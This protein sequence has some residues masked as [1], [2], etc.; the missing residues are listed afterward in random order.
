MGCNSTRG[1]GDLEDDKKYADNE[2]RPDD[3]TNGNT[4][5]KNYK[6]N[7]NDNN[8]NKNGKNANNKNANNINKNNGNKNDNKNTNKDDKNYGTKGD[9]K[10]TKNDDKN[11]GNKDVKKDGNTKGESKE[12][13]NINTDDNTN[14]DNDGNREARKVNL[15]LQKEDYEGVLLMQG[16]DDCFPED[17]TEEDVYKLVQDA[18][19]DKIVDDEEN[20]E[21]GTINTKQA[22]AIANILYNKINKK[23]TDNKINLKKYPELKG[24]NC[25]VGVEKFT[26]DVVK[27]MMF[28]DKKVDDKQIDKAYSKI[29]KDNDEYKALTIEILQ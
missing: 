11:S 7:K 23:D 8:D 21:P 10:N 26:K 2:S 1:F 19:N 25:K 5:N 27:K 13:E 28:Q 9:N 14:Q 3:D 16:F 17:L 24:V 29:N 15:N 20:K 18:L 6:E 4:N 22:K 12:G